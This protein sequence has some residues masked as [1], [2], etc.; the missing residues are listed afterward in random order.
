MP[1]AR[2]LHVA[3]SVRRLLL[4][5]SPEA[6]F[7]NR[8]FCVLRLFGYLAEI[9]HD[10]SPHLSEFASRQCGGHGDNEM[11]SERR[12]RAT[13]Q[14]ARLWYGIGVPKGTVEALRSQKSGRRRR[15]FRNQWI[16]RN[17]GMLGCSGRL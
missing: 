10:D 8:D 9:D 1:I 7:A 3:A 2:T 12:Q 16:G 15:V 17:I 13:Y 4:D 6:A 5:G 11:E 14:V